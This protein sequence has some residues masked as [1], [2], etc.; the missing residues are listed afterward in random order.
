M[1]YLILKLSHL[2]CT[3][4]QWQ[5]MKHHLSALEDAVKP[6]VM[7]AVLFMTC[8]AVLSHLHY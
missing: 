7:S 6:S 3:A 2:L 1:C 4:L 5:S 8:S